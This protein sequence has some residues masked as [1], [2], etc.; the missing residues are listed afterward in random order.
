LYLPRQTI[1]KL[2]KKTE[3]LWTPFSPAKEPASISRRRRVLICAV[4]FLTAFGVR[5]L[6]WQDNRPLFPKVF[7]GM[8]RQYRDNAQLL[9]K[10]DLK[11]FVAG[12][13]PPADANILTYPP[14]YP[15][16][17][18]AIF[19]L[20]GESDSALRLAQVCGDSLVAVIIFFLAVELLPA[21][22][23][24]IAGVLTAFSPQLSYYSLLLI[25]D[26]PTTVPILLAIYCLVLAYKRPRM[27]TIV[28]A[29][30]FL[31]L[32]CWLRA[33]A[34]LLA[35]FLAVVIMILFQ[36]GKRL[37]FAAALVCTTILVI[38]PITI[39][40]ALVFG[41]FIPLSLT[42]GVAFTI[43]IADYDEA[44]RFD[45]PRS[46]IETVRMEAERDNRP[47]YLLSLFGGDGVARERTR[48][49]RG[50]AVVR[51]HPF[52]FA[53]VLLRR[54]ASMLR[55]ERV[56]RVSPAPGVVHS[57]DAAA[58][59]PPVWSSTASDFLS[60]QPGTTTISQS[61]DA[62]SVNLMSDGMG[63]PIRS[64]PIAVEKDTDYLLNIPVK[65]ARGNV[66]IFVTGED[67]SQVYGST[68]ILNPLETWTPNDPTLEVL[69][70][71]FASQDA[72][73]VRVVIKNSNSRPVPTEAR[74]G[75]AELFRLGPAGLAATRYLRLFVRLAQSVFLTAWMLPLAVIGATLLLLA[76]RKE[77]VLILLAVA[78]YY[79]CFQSFLHTEYR[80]VMAL[81]PFLLVLVAVALYSFGRVLLRPARP[82]RVW[83]AARRHAFR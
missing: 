19:K 24:I 35:P 30:L 70:I 81:Q 67:E 1:D 21:G 80:Y 53:G 59:S 46:D 66:V 2:L 73:T 76:G 82:L 49:A 50:L 15:L 12:P 17:S 14:G 16:L 56:A 47:D 36:P 77:T 5:M 72:R 62:R 13:A 34:L 45:M 48:L 69:Q 4:L 57:L 43:G 22:A 11:T 38:A 28:L 37:R 31:G 78:I 60:T 58:G 51:A 27:L 74:I 41:H 26:S 32:A 75:S 39:R 71:P 3:V 25:P 52:W 54:G 10:G 83:L 18:A 63:T 20:F 61:V 40:N 6:H 9:L 65:V 8:V 7:I 42:A 33:N 23:A 79:V 44:N 55:L 64:Q 68:P 29:G